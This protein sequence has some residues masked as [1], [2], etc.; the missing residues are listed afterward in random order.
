[1]TSPR[2]M[3]ETGDSMLVHWDTP[4]VWDGEE[5]GTVVWDG[6]GGGRRVQDRGHMYTHG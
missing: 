3:H 6:A 5:G 4:E 1:M 2:L